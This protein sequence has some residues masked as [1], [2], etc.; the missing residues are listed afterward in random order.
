MGSKKY[1]PMEVDTDK[2]Q[3]LTTRYHNKDIQKSCFVLPN[4]VQELLK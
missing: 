1:D 3:V 2:L 4:F